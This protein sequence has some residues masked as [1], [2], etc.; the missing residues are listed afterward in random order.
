M[1]IDRSAVL[2]ALALTF[3]LGLVI[4]AIGAVAAAATLT[5]GNATSGAC[6]HTFTSIQSAVNV[7]SLGDTIQVCQGTY[8]ENVNIPLGLT[9]RGPNFGISPNGG[10]RV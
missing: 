6:P 4:F 10:T 9:L 8:I 3:S 5:V 2:R 1:N 7:A